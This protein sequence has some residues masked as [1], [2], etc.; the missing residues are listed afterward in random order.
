MKVSGTVSRPPDE[1]TMIHLRAKVLRERLAAR[2]DDDRKVPQNSAHIPVP[3]WIEIEQ[4]CEGGYLLSHIYLVEGPFIHTWHS[5]IDEAMEEAKVE[6]GIREEEWVT[7]A[8]EA[9]AE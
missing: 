3:D 7:V 5:T 1:V 4:G 6:F 2:P 9:Q 8:L